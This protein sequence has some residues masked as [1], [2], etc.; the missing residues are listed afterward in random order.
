MRQLFRLVTVCALI[1][2]GGLAQ[3]IPLTGTS[4]NG[5]LYVYSVGTISARD[6]IVDSGVEFS[7]TG[8]T[9]AFTQADLSDN[10]ITLTFG[11]GTFEGTGLSLSWTFRIDPS[12]SFSSITKT[13]DN[14][15]NG[16]RVLGFRDNYATLTMDRQYSLPYQTFQAVYAITLSSANPV[17]APA[18]L[19]LFGLGLAGLGWTRR[20]KA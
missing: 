11:S 14:F 3:A 19:A 12:L 6:A 20:K 1:S 2:W 8:P 16:T 7:F 4:V 13:S 18:T 10:S 9:G 17:P 5:A 15:V